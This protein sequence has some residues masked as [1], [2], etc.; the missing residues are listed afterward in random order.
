ML[1]GPLMPPAQAAPSQAVDFE[2]LDAGA[3]VDIQYRELGITF[4]SPRALEYSRGLSNL[5]RSGNRAIEQCYAEEFCTRPLEIRF[6]S[7]QSRVG[8]WIGSSGLVV[9]GQDERRTA[10]LRGIDVDGNE[11]ARAATDLVG[12][13]PIPI[14]EALEVISDSAA[15]T[16]AVLQLLSPDG[17][18]AETNGLAVDDLEF[19]GAGPAPECPSTEAP[20]IFITEPTDGET[21][22][23]NAFT[24]RG[25]ILTDAPVRQLTLKVSNGDDSAVTVIP[26]GIDAPS[27]EFGSPSLVGLLFPGTNTIT[28][29][30]ESCAGTGHASLD[31]ALDSVAGA[32]AADVANPGAFD[33][34]QPT[35]ID[36]EPLVE[37]EDPPRALTPPRN[38]VAGVAFTPTP[39]GI[40]WRIGPVAPLISRGARGAFPGDGASLAE[41]G[42]GRIDF[43]DGPASYFSLLVSSDTLV[44]LVAFSVEGT[45]LTSTDFVEPER[46]QM[47]EL[48]IERP[49]ADIGYVEV[50]SVLGANRD[51]A[52]DAICTDAPVGPRY[53]AMG[54]SYSSGEGAPPFDP[55]TN[56]L[57]NFCHRSMV[58]YPQILKARGD[59]PAVPT[60]GH[61]A[62]S[63][64]VVRDFYQPTVH[65]VIFR[66]E[67]P[68]LQLLQELFNGSSAAPGVITIGVGGN[69]IGFS[70][71]LKQCVSV[72][73]LGQRNARYN[74]NCRV[75]LNIEAIERIDALATGIR[76][77]GSD[78]GRL[79]LP[80]LYQDVR[81]LAPGAQVVALGY[82]RITLPGAAQCGAQ[83]RR[84]NGNAAEATVDTF[85]VDVP[86]ERDVN[87]KIT[88]ENVEW[89][90]KLTERLNGTIQALATEVGFTYV[91]I[92]DLFGG[93]E[94]C[95]RDP[96]VHGLVFQNNDLKPSV[97]SFHPNAKGHQAMADA[98]AARIR[99]T[100]APAPERDADGPVAVILADDQ[101]PGRFNFAFDASRSA[102]FSGEIVRYGWDFGD[103]T[104]RSGPQVNHT[105][106]TIGRQVITLTVWDGAGR[107]DVA[108]EFIDTFCPFDAKRAVIVNGE[109]RC[110]R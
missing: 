2:K 38:L 49:R 102:A 17:S 106:R 36:F 5:P 94:A 88:A 25:S 21:L 56:G 58:A 15:I 101:S 69:D 6:T 29:E 99:G 72:T 48:R 83:A 9:R 100:A 59:T 90:N 89:M 73:S 10:L 41:K 57:Y 105:F 104:Q 30:A 64:A 85:L 76:T 92:Q 65:G 110:Q 27:G 70:E 11:V 103:G 7:G 32:V 66:A 14:R 62:C 12:P 37:F 107:R 40:P 95:S 63:G 33:C 28:V 84:E 98:V 71:I 75:S 60:E 35:F 31:M 91:D 82:P 86:L 19:S 42:V 46:G 16:M 109:L 81:R 1:A 74:E 52:V 51:F 68:Q 8:L 3:F 80:R 47:V 39:F 93:H 53:A 34:A 50:R 26:V 67:A 78:D 79:S 77:F 55:R 23:E 44:F 54:D 43:V 13:A 22:R 20:A 97:F 18:V 108:I 96:W 87:W 61:I 4:N 45:R 24:L